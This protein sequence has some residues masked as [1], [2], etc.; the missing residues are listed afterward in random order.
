MSKNIE[1]EKKILMEEE[2]GSSIALKAVINLPVCR[3]PY[4]V[5]FANTCAF[6]AKDA[7]SR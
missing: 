4:S 7:T 5:Y 1:P 2:S 6:K 3:M